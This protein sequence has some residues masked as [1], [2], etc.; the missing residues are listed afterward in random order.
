ML[1]RVLVWVFGF[2]AVAYGAWLALL[3]FQQRS[4]LFPGVGM[5]PVGGL[6]PP[7]DAETVWFDG[8]G[9]R[10]EAWL[11]PADVPEGPA[12]PAIIFAHGNGEFIDELAEMFRPLRDAGVHVL[13]VEYPG[14]GRST[15]SPTQENVT[16]V[17][18][19]AYDWL[20]ERSDVDADR[21][22]GM[23]RSLGGGVIMAL[24]R[25]RAMA[26]IVLQSTFI[27][28]SA[29]ARS[30]LVPGWLVRDAFD[31]ESGLRAYDGPVLLGHGRR[32]RII[33]FRHGQRLAEVSGGE[34]TAWDC[35]HND[36]PP[37]W[38]AYLERVIGFLRAQGVVRGGRQSG[39]G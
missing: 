13:L 4:M 1:I 25:R 30:Y 11:L 26:A 18:A 36:C 32:D 5:D 3:Y 39:S 27:S 7:E 6:G 33:P 8:P 34:L 12:A 31:N 29:M 38:Q 23:G 2:A 20:T 24:S 16:E 10:A 28:V 15:G 35:G 14:Y 22:V 19:E 9:V 37:D 17:V 21:I